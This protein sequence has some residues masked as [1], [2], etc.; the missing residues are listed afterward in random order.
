MA[1][2][3]QSRILISILVALVTLWAGW[4][5]LKLT[6][7]G[8][9]S[10]VHYEQK[11]YL[12]WKLKRQ[13][14]KIEP[15]TASTNYSA[16]GWMQLVKT[17]QSF[18]NVPPALAAETLN[19]LLKRYAGKSDQLSVEQ[20]RVFLLIRAVFDLPEN[21]SSGQRRTFA[22]WAR[23][24]SDLNPD[25]TVNL[26]WPLSWSQDKPRLVAGC[27]GAAGNDYSAGDEFAFLRYRFKY[28]DLSRVRW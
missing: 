16:A 2:S 20:G 3:R 12:K 15:W 21:G 6:V 8:L 27:E 5:L 24:R 14:R 4:Q 25:G 13:V 18:Q 1:T 11:V 9:G 28:R 19:E 22:S 23:G 7:R 17:A 10:F 26:A